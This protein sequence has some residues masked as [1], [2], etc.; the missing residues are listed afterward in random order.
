MASLQH[1][2]A[3]TKN[4]LRSDSFASTEKYSDGLVHAR[5]CLK[6]E[7]YILTILKDK[8]YS[9]NKKIYNIY[10]SKKLNKFL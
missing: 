7:N 10:D 1:F 9:L 2:S 5:F 4:S 8:V 3:L 6:N